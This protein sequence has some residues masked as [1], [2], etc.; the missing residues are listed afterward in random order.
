VRVAGEGITDDAAPVV[1]TCG[2]RR[3]EARASDT[4]ASALV[5]DG[6]RTC[7]TTSLGDARGVF[8]G[9]GVCNECA[10]VVDGRPSTL[11]CMTP[12]R[13]GMTV[14]VQP[15]ARLLEA[16]AQ[17]EL[18]ETELAP[19]VLV[20]GGGPAGL[21]AA[22]AAAEAGADVVLVDERGKL[23]GQ[24]Y[25]QPAEQLT[26]D[27][28]RLDR[29]YRDGRALVRRVERAGVTVL[30]GAAV[31][32]AF[33]PDHLLAAG[34]DERWVLRP[35][36]LVLATGAYER[37]VP[38]PGWTLPGVV[39]TGA[40]QTLLRSTQVAPGRRVLVSGNGPLNLQVAAELTRAGVTVVALAE[41]ADLRRPSLA[42]AH[43]RMAS[44]APR[45]VRDGAGYLATL[46]RA[47]V[48]VLH[49]AA[50]VR[51]EGSDHVQRA[52]VARLDATGRPVA[53]TE[54]SFE[55]DA[56]C[57]GFGFLPSNE[58][59][60]SLGCRHSYDE[61]RGCLTV[62]HAPDGRTSVAGVRVVGDSAAVAGAKVAQAVGLLAGAAA[63]QECGHPL[64]AAL[65]QEVSRA[66]RLRERHER[67]QAALWRVYR[68]PVLVDQLAEPETVACRCES[69][70]L[71]QITEAV[72][73]SAAAAGS[74]GA[75][76]RVTRAGMG[77]CQGR[78][79]GPLLT[80][81]VARRT[82]RPVD[83]L[84]GF[85]PQVPYKPVPISLVA[86]PADA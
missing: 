8:C 21:A 53:G 6:A 78:Y 81:V 59:A 17:P 29:Q 7:R 61:V 35:R 47:R 3:V 63:A 80:T 11:A 22:A 34:S 16:A 33:A 71:R 26:V 13:D 85:A 65:Q 48:P 58:V 10:M 30:K 79:C 52:T 49:G 73:A 67:F 14:E 5:H 62:D 36:S 82:G 25:K 76:K 77:K 4:V 83:E 41:L 43:L 45:L 66:E 1:L 72:D 23:G 69:L 2:G 64:P 54:R 32:A 12:V 24:Y 56:V 19:D 86:D 20:L 37:G 68:A 46:A 9:M 15:P 50:V 55:V 27:E 18:P 40:A 39:T 70:T 75:L 60:R 31:W 44:T 57:V 51:V 38:V 42:G 74:A 28:Q 84:A